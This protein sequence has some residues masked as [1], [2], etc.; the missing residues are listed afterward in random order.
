MIN[1]D[2]FTVISEPSLLITL[3]ITISWADLSTGWY[4]FV[5]VHCFV[6][7]V[8]K[9]PAQSPD[10]L[11]VYSGKLLSVIEKLPGSK[12]TLVPDELPSNEEGSG[13][14]PSTVIVKSDGS[15]SPPPSLTTCLVTISLGKTPGIN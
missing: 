5:I 14:L 10:L 12:L 11:E 2:G 6:S 8:L 13:L 15:A 3:F 7:P 1:A 4:M 9:L